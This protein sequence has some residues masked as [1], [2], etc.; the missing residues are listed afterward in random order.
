M[1]PEGTRV[2]RKT[3]RAAVKGSPRGRRSTHQTLISAPRRGSTWLRRNPS[4]DDFWFWHANAGRGRIPAN[5][6][7]TG[8]PDAPGMP[9]ST[10]THPPQH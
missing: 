7:T 1:R 3:A 4:D 10:D 8:T 9:A 5:K 2:W 6:K